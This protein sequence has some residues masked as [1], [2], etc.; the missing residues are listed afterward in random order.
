MTSIDRVLCKQK[1]MLWSVDTHTYL[2]DLLHSAINQ[3]KKSTEVTEISFN[4]FLMSNY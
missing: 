2:S 1:K 3:I 4:T